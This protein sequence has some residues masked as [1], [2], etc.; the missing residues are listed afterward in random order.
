MGNQAVPKIDIY[1]LIFQTQNCF[2]LKLKR[3]QTVTIA[4]VVLI[5]NVAVTT[6]RDISR[7]C[8]RALKCLQVYFRRG[9]R[10]LFRI[11]V[12]ICDF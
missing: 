3:V 1:T 2:K 7:Q 4:S 10:R 11:S 8:K 9:G 5:A 6:A 12:T